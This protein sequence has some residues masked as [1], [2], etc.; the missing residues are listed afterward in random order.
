MDTSGNYA[1]S[2]IKICAPINGKYISVGSLVTSEKLYQF[3][4]EKKVCK[5]RTS[6]CEVQNISSLPARIPSKLKAMVGTSPSKS[7][8]KVNLRQFREHYSNI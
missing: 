1:K 3:I 5:K 2:L 4:N 8:K 7:E 6:C